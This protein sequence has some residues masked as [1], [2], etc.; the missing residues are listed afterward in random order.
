MCD[1]NMT[2]FDIAWL[3]GSRIFQRDY[4]PLWGGQIN[5]W[6]LAFFFAVFRPLVTPYTTREHAGSWQRTTVFIFDFFAWHPDNLTILKLLDKLKGKAGC[7]LA[8]CRQCSV[9]SLTC[10]TTQ[11]QSPQLCRYTAQ[12]QQ[13]QPAHVNQSFRPGRTELQMLPA[14]GLIMSFDSGWPKLGCPAVHTVHMPVPC[15]RIRA[16]CSAM[17]IILWP[18]AVAH[19]SIET[20]LKEVLIGH[21]KFPPIIKKS[22]QLFHWRKLRQ[23]P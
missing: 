17:R 4:F 7:T 14:A 15:H 19:K 11:A 1:I 16:P 10:V 2:T 23:S 18:F 12:Q 20:C 9:H 6:I 5:P 3:L 8:P 21:Q 22:P 13:Q